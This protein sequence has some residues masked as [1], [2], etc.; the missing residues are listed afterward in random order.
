MRRADGVTRRAFLPGAAAAPGEGVTSSQG[1]EGDST[2]GSH[3]APR[4]VCGVTAA[5]PFVVGFDLDMTLIDTR[6]GFAATLHALGAETGVEMDVESMCANLGPPL[7]HLL[8]PYFPADRLAGLVARFRALYPDIAVP[9]TLALPGAHGGSTVLVTGKFTPNAA[10]H[11]DALGFD[12]DHL[13][14]EGWGFGK[15]GVLRERGASV[16]V[17]DHVHDVEGARAAGALSVSVLTGGSTDT[18]RA[19]AARAPSTSCTWSPT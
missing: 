10:L 7:D 1:A 16:Y 19:P 14:G 9:P 15:A 5:A 11:V 4:T 3:K 12:V 2:P 6:P 18:L 8:A 13:A 17:G